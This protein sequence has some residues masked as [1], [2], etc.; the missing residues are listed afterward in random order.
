MLVLSF[1][2]SVPPAL[3]PGSC[4]ICF[5]P[6]SPA[7]S[8]EVRTTPT[9]PAPEASHPTHRST[10]GQVKTFLALCLGTACLFLLQ[11]P[12]LKASS[13]AGNPN[14]IPACHMGGEDRGT[15]VGSPIPPGTAEQRGLRAH[16]EVSD[17]SLSA[18]GEP[19]WRGPRSCL[20]SPSSPCLCRRAW[21]RCSLLREP[22]GLFFSAVYGLD[23]IV[24]LSSSQ[25]GNFV[26]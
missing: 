20:D 21:V 16:N 7:P 3:V 25:V 19:M 11:V 9:L 24:F 4:H 10:A 22:H 12:S 6:A 17:F 13:P 1:L 18:F 26:F 23:R 5:L 2:M 14:P 8:L 15:M